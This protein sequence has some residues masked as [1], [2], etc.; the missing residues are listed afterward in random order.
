MKLKCGK[1]EASNGWVAK[2]RPRFWKANASVFGPEWFNI[3]RE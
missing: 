2:R 3:V 1:L